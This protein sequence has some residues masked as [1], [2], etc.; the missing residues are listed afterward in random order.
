ML[1]PNCLVK[2]EENIKTALKK[3]DKNQC[4]LVFVVDDKNILL[5]SL[6]DGDIRRLILGGVGINEAIGERY[7]A[8]PVTV[9]EG[10]INHKVCKSLFLRLHITM[11]PV[12]NRGNV[13]T[14]FIKWEDVFDKAEESEELTAETAVTIP[15]VVMAGGKGTRMA[16]FTN[17]LPK[18]LIPIGDKTIL[19]LIIESFH[20]YGIQDFLLTINYRGEMIQ[21]YF[22]SIEKDY[23][24]QY[25]KET[26]FLGTAGALRLLGDQAAP[27]FFVSNCD[28]LVKANYAEVLAF[29][30]SSGASL[31]MV[32]SIQHQILPYGVVQFR[33]G[34]V[35]TGM[36]EKPENSYSINT[37]VYILERKCL[38]LIPADKEFHMT[39]LIEALLRNKQKV[40]TYPV[41]SGDYVDIGQWE[42]YT[43]AVTMLRG[44]V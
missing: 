37:G 30:R 19:E 36:I 31:T 3:I 2:P 38:D 1:D 23:N 34:G 25:L 33:E 26:K 13:V 17:V 12:V 4:K 20:K 43:N 29:H 10:K 35:V 11:I 9:R 5:G 15:V 14:G 39:H 21:A 18:P 7:H 44:T 6:S 27:T 24:I 8:H 16:P 22:N 41:S 42:E 28:I 32:S 40:V